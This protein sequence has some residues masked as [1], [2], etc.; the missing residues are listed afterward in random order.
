[1]CCEGS[2]CGIFARSSYAVQHGSEAL[3]GSATPSVHNTTVSVEVPMRR[4][5]MWVY[6]SCFT[7]PHGQLEQ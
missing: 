7:R 6:C 3:V 4:G 1:M 5:L 2:G